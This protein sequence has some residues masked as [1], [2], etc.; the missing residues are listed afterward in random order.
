MIRKDLKQFIPTDNFNPLPAV[1]VVELQKAD[2]VTGGLLWGVLFEAEPSEP[3]GKEFT[4][5][6]NGQTFNYINRDL[7]FFRDSNAN[8][9][10]DIQDKSLGYAGVPSLPEDARKQVSAFDAPSIGS[11]IWKAYSSNEFALFDPNGDKST[12][13]LPIPDGIFS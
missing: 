13:N 10:F 9:K 6:Y 5:Q 7:E 1:T 4:G 11:G 3:W 12:G 2:P 8:N